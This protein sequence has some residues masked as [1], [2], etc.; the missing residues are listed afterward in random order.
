MKEKKLKIYKVEEIEDQTQSSALA[1][2][3][4][5]KLYNHHR[6]FNDACR[7]QIFHEDGITNYRMTWALALQGALFTMAYNTLKNNLILLIM[8][9]IIGIL[10]SISSII[11]LRKNEH[12]ISNIT[13]SWNN[14]IEKHHIDKDDFPLVWA[15]SDGNNQKESFKYNSFMLYKISPWIL[16]IAWIVMIIIGLSN[17]LIITIRP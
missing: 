4:D 1:T 11:S 2:M 8:C 13:R 9:S 3:K 14:Y 16:L 15:A 17:V 5:V 6:F 12:A 10:F 7:Q